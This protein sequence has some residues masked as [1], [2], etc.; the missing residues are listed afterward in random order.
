MMNLYNHISKHSKRSF[1][2]YNN[3]VFSY[4]E[5]VE[6]ANRIRNSLD[7]FSVS[8]QSKVVLYLNNPLDFIEAW[9]G[10][11]MLP[12]TSIIFHKDLTNSELE[13][14]IAKINPDVI[15]S[16]WYNKSQILN[17][18]CTKIYIEECSGKLGG[19]PIPRE[20]FGGSNIISILMTSGTES[21]FKFVKL[22][23]QSLI[24]S[25]VMWNEQ[26]KFKKSDIFC[27]SLPL[28]HIS[29]LSILIRAIIFGC[30]IKLLD[31][32]SSDNIYKLI[33]NN[34]IEWISLVPS[35]LS[36]LVKY[37]FSKFNSD[38]FRGI[39]LG[40]S[41]APK[42]LL[43][44]SINKNIPIFYSYG[45]TE[46]A[47]GISGFWIHQS[48]NKL[49][50]CGQLFC[51]VDIQFTNKKNI[52]IKSKSNMSGYLNASLMQNEY[53]ETNDYGYLD[54]EGFLYIEGRKDD[55]IISGGKNISIKEIENIII[56]HKDIKDVSVLGIPDKK[57]GQKLVAYIVTISE[58]NKNIFI[59]E[60][61]NWQKEFISKY[62]I[63]K[64][65]KFI[66]KIPRSNLGKINYKKMQNFL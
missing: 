64:D 42:H 58:V 13:A 19:C 14:N 37:D 29:G 27:L 8:H 7:L 61:I 31:Q 5:V 52:K 54:K 30:Q 22:S 63:P 48:L 23:E 66:C 3:R 10:C 56:Q 25:A 24:N 55:I 51:G 11:M 12:V 26:L 34:K 20:V 4:S 44:L 1:I 50:S 33:Y 57:W 43:E 21:D 40:G 60:L 6:N 59:E 65:Y 39:I 45:M 38:K 16:S 46:T 17:F 47:S 62:K 32:Y 41:S 49:E 28:S 35:M 36:D 2:D 18:K 15:I 53:I 9:I